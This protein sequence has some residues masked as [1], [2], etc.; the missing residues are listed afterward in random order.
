MEGESKF[1]ITTDTSSAEARIA[2]MIEKIQSMAI[3]E[4]LTAWQKE[5]MRRRVPN[6]EIIS[7]THAM[8]VI[9]PRSRK[10]R[11]EKVSGLFRTRRLK[12]QSKWQRPVRRFS[13]ATASTHVASTRPILRQELFDKLCE[14]MRALMKRELSWASIKSG[15]KT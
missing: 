14:R 7:P 4:E 1:W 6:T 11:S 15:E 9:W 3:T 10:Q 5:D 2:G 12:R 13:K 8:T